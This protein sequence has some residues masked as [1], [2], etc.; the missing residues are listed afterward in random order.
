MLKNWLFVAAMMAV[1]GWKLQR[2]TALF[3]KI[4]VIWTATA[5]SHTCIP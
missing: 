1:V 2:L 4:A 3:V 5:C